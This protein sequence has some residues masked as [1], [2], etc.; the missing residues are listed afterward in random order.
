MRRKSFAKCKM[1]A[2]VNSPND[3]LNTPLP[4]VS[5]TGL[6]ISSGN[7][8]LSKP[9]ERECTHRKF[10][11]IPNTFRNSASEPDQLKSTL[12][13]VAV[14]SNAS[15]E[16]PTTVFTPA[17]FICSIASCGSAGSARARIVSVLMGSSG[18]A[19]TPQSRRALSDKRSLEKSNQMFNAQH[20]TPQIRA[21]YN[22]PLCSQQW[23]L[24][25]RF[26]SSTVYR[27]DSRVSQGI[28]C[29]QKIPSH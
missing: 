8:A 29:R 6:S 21:S 18:E 12:A 5:G 28:L 7:S 1:A 14:C 19:I 27:T 9:T 15:T 13:S 22:T 26:Q 17:S 23:L 10:G 24:T 16:S 2:S 11:Q 3:A 25:A 20:L 4:F